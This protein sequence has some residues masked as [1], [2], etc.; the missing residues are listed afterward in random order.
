[1][2]PHRLRAY[3]YLTLVALIWGAA[4]PIVKFTLGGI[5]PFAFLSYRFAISAVLAIIYFSIVGFKLPKPKK[6]LL[7][8]ILYGLLAFTIAL[9]ALF[10]GLDRSTV[11]DLTLISTIS[12]LIIAFGGAL[13]FREHITRREKL[14]IAI[15]VV[16]V[17]INNFYSL[18]SGKTDLALSGNLFLLLFLLADTGSV[19]LAKKEVRDRIPAFTLT[20]IGFIVAAITF[21]AYT[22]STIGLNEFINLVFSLP[23]QYHLGVWYMAI[24]SGTIAYS[25]WV[26][27]QQSIEV[28]EAALFYYLQPIFA[29]PLAVIWLGEKITPHFMVGAILIAT[30][31][32]IAE[33]KKRRK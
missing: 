9:G 22:L 13:F 1:M 4:G 14:G 28:S 31:V 19:L 32:V 20:N 17:L 7:P 2:N 27:G 21:N 24:F 5:S 10:V 26:R 15:V 23:F 3:I 6:T 30:G 16:G 18:L 29:I 8:A 33:Y 25:L 12:P 11:L